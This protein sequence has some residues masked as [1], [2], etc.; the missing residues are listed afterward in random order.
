MD[1]FGFLVREINPF[2][3]Q[4]LECL[5]SIWYLNSLSS[6]YLLILHYASGIVKGTWIHSWTWQE[7]TNNTVIEK[8]YQETKQGDVI[9]SDMSGQKSP[10]GR[11]SIN[12]VTFTGLQ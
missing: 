10:L 6:K 3:I 1:I 4:W 11:V 7:K 8:S 2:L 12:N 9:K 5:I